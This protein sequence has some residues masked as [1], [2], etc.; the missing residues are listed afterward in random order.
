VRGAIFVI[1]RGSRK[2]QAWVCG[3]SLAGI[4]GSNAAGGGDVCCECCVLSGRGLC[5]GLI[6]HPEESCRLVC[7]WVWSRNLKN[8]EAMARFGQQRHRDEGRN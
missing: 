1:N 6:I 5:V 2:I 7:R 8:E 3:L 4:A